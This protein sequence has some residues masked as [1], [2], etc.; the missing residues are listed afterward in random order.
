MA[1]SCRND[2]DARDNKPGHDAVTTNETNMDSSSPLTIDETSIRYDG[3]RIVA[4]CFW[5]AIFGWSFGFYGQTVFVA[6]LHRL[7]GWPTSL[8]SSGTTLFYL[9]GA[10][11]RGAMRCRFTAASRLS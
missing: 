9:L 3:W 7:H 4:V 2:V 10:M 11:R 5:V 8:V 6:E 1:S